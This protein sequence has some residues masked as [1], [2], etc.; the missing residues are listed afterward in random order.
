M[1]NKVK[2][3]W[4]PEAGTEGPSP[5]GESS[6]TSSLELSWS[7]LIRCYGEESPRG[8]TGTPRTVLWSISEVCQSA[9]HSH[10]QN[11][12][13]LSTKANHYVHSEFNSRD[14]VFLEPMH[15]P[16]QLHEFSL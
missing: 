13:R 15:L 9:R 3:S 7:L 16:F 6:L 14:V 8:G 1:K 5:G 4:E 11:S 12:F 2:L 10:K